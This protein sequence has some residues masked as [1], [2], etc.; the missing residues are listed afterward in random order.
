M[1]PHCPHF[2][3]SL[4]IRI[5]ASVPLLDD[6]QH[7][8]E[9]VSHVSVQPGQT[10]PCA[11]YNDPPIKNGAHRVLYIR[12]KYGSGSFSY[13]FRL[14]R[15]LL[16]P[17]RHPVRSP[18]DHRCRPSSKGQH[19]IYYFHRLFSFRN[20]QTEFPYYYSTLCSRNFEN[21]WSNDAERRR[22]PS[23]RNKTQIKIVSALSATK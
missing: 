16:G 20:I 11:T 15:H 3:D 17:W 21:Y 18:R 2:L 8:G 13:L 5:C 10:R 22:Q 7:P 9:E 23:R 12:R 19:L 14:K 6:V 1:G 4:R